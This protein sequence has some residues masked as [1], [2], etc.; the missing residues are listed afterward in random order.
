LRVGY[1]KSEVGLDKEKIKS[2]DAQNGGEDRGPAPQVDRRNHNDEQIHHHQVGGFKAAAN[3]EAHGGGHSNQRHAPK[4]TRP[5]AVDPQDILFGRHGGLI[6][7]GHHVH[8]DISAQPH[9]IIDDRTADD[10]LPAG[11]GG[12][13]NDLRDVVL[14]GKFQDHLGGRRDRP[15]G[16][17][18][19]GARAELLCLEQDAGDSIALL[20]G[21]GGKLR[22]FHIDGHP[23]GVELIGQPAGGADQALAERTRTDGDQ[24]SFGGGPGSRDGARLH[25]RPHLVVDALSRTAHGHLAQGSEIP[26]AEEI[27]D[28]TRGLF[29][30]VDFALL[31]ALE[32][33]V[34]WQ[35]D[36]L[37]LAGFIDDTIGNG[38]AHHDAR[39]LGDD[40]VQALEVLDIEGGIDVD[41]RIE[42]I[43][44]ILVALG[45]PGSGGIGM[46]QLVH[47]GEGRVA[48]DH[49]VHIH[50]GEVHAVI[51]N[52][53]GGE[54]LEPLHHCLRL[55]TFVRLDVADNDV[56]ALVPSLACGLEHGIGLAHASSVAEEDPEFPP[57][58]F[59]RLDLLQQLIG[60]GTLGHNSYCIPS[61]ARFARGR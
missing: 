58:R 47:E 32:Q 10:L 6:G 40:V 15:A 9:K 7:A 11:A 28:G 46:G 2:Q 50:F 13:D 20:S 59:F 61:E 3:Q 38:L 16:A 37:D 14:A 36:Q 45:M 33:L 39:D 12:S 53:L 49:P 41:A 60:I 19:V 18:D 55:G 26:L 23:F 29:R 17:E 51:F 21:H 57:V 54:D 27:L 35:V 34:R 43:L 44:H 8:I 25:V 48:G 1:G 56:H 30:D 31:H 5:A 42:Q 52:G 22:G 4:I 24:E